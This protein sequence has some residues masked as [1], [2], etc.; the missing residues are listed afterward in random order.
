MRWRSLFS[1]IVSVSF[2]KIWNTVEMK[3][4]FIVSGMFLEEF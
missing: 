4:G 3:I 1:W 2:S